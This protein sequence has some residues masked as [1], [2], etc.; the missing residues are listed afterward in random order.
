MPNIRFLIALVVTFG[1]QTAAVAQ[2][3]ATDTPVV[4]LEFPGDSLE[5][6]LSNAFPGLDDLNLSPIR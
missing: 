3:P 2:S 5:E 6:P 4:T 1:V